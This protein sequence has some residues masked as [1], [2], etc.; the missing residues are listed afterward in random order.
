[1]LETAVTGNSGAVTYSWSPAAGL[2]DPTSPNPTANPAVTT[3]Y[4]VTATDEAMC[5]DV[6]TVTVYAA[7]AALSAFPVANGNV[8]ASVVI[9]NIAYVGG[10]F[11]QFGGMPRNRLAAV[12]LN[13]GMVTSW[14]PGANNTVFALETDGTN[15]YVGGQFTI[16]GGGVR[17][18]AGALTPGGVLTSF[19]PDANSIV[20][21]IALSGATAYLG[22]EFTD[23]GSGS[24]KQRLA[25]VNKTTGAVD[26]TFTAN[27]NNTVRALLV[28]GGTLYVGG[29]F[30][31]IQSTTRNRVA[32]IDLATGN[33]TGFNPNVN[34]SVRALASHG[35]FIYLG[36]D[37][38]QVSSLSRPRLARVNPVTGAPDAFI[39]S[40]NNTVTEINISGNVLYFGGS[41]S[42]VFSSSR[43]NVAAIDLTTD[44]LKPWNPSANNTVQTIFGYGCRI[45]FGGAFTVADGRNAENF[46]AVND[47]EVP[48]VSVSG[49]SNH[50]PG[51]PS[52]LTASG[53]TQY[54]WCNTAET[55]ASIDVDPAM[56]T[57]YTVAA[58]VGGCVVTAEFTLNVSG[59]ASV[60]I[61]GDTEG[62]VGETLVLDAGP[63]FVSYQWFK[64]GNPLTGETSQTL[65]VTTSGLYSVDVL[66]DFGCS[67]SDEVTV[68][69]HPL[70]TVD[71]G[72][73]VTI[74]VG[75][76]TTLTASGADSYVWEPGSL[77]GASVSV[78]PVVTTTYT[79]T[80][81]DANSCQ[82]T[83]VVTVTVHALPVVNAGSDVTICA[84]QSTTLTASGADSY[85]W[86]PG[87]LPGA[88]VSV[89][90]VVT[91][92]YTVTGT[93]ANGCTNTDEVVVTVNALPTVSVSPASVSINLGDFTTLTASGASSYVWMPGSLSGASVSVSPAS[94]TTYTVTGTDANGCVNTATV[95]VTVN[96]V[97]SAPTGISQTPAGV[98]KRLISWNATP[99]AVS[100]ALAYGPITQLPSTWT[101]VIV[102]APTT[103]RLLES[104]SPTVTYRARVLANCT[105]PVTNTAPTAGSSV[106]SSTTSSF[107]PSSRIA[108]NILDKASLSLYPNP[109]KGAFEIKVA[110]LTGMATLEVYDAMGRVVY[111]SKF[112]LSGSDQIPV[113]LSNA[114]GGVYAVKLTVGE[115]GFTA[116]TVVE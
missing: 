87:A 1:M 65:S 28:E 9:G 62:C 92:T 16:L 80:G 56:T 6:A 90:P 39:P 12:D 8:N 3:T 102:N 19:D 25:A 79:V 66:N 97:C 48:T 36:G 83:D 58:I 82:N 14:D 75:Q 7:P 38:T 68:V 106:W 35:G 114:A 13:S 40:P 50:C 77:P 27:A 63:G 108:E 30:N 113:V 60:T 91:T 64:D 105:S 46:V 104:L 2:D 110:A 99:G 22:G 5:T 100:Y 112:E 93:D 57:N 98:G 24:G 72:S 89:S 21:A 107:K 49:P 26:M 55:T 84:G 59:A 81:T 47:G 103:N 17:R 88:S 96:P 34:N 115:R 54:L 71:A 67:D 74:C 52:T 42:S 70:P 73:D 111:S 78:S 44:A 101:T 20:R 95:E 23:V 43:A 69:F 10:S 76:S 94:T 11:T 51:T 41:F 18:R 85:V 86:N 15:I 29:D 32:A 61:T 116:K 53:A 45:F 4:T 31:L 37:F 33:L 109:N